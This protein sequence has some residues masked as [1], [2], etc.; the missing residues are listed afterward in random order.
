MEQLNTLWSRS[1]LGHR[2]HTHITCRRGVL[3]PGEPGQLIARVNSHGVGCTWVTRLGKVCLAYQV[4]P[5]AH[6]SPGHP[7]GDV[8]HVV[9]ALQM[10]STSFLGA[11]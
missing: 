11:I 4:R 6:D 3:R 7:V 1:A 9:W 5:S 2:W 8:V 10:A